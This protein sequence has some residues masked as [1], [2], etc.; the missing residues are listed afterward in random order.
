[1]SLAG[2]LSLGGRTTYVE[3]TPETAARLSA[4]ETRV[5]ALEQALSIQA[6]PLGA[7]QPAPSDSPHMPAAAYSGSP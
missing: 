5:S 7:S 2:C 1:M 6:L 4:L 3:E